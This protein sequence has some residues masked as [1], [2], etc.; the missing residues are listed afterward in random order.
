MLDKYFNLKVNLDFIALKLLYNSNI[1]NIELITGITSFS[2]ETLIIAQ[3]HLY[4]NTKTVAVQLVKIVEN[5]LY[6]NKN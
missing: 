2:L 6:S 1:E 3:L 5:G 4:F